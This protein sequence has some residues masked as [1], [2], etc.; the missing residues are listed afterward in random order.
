MIGNLGEEYIDELLEL[1]IGV[2]L[3][4]E[5]EVNGK[6]ILVR[7]DLNL[8]ITNGKVEDTTRLD[9]FATT[10][11]RELIEKD[12][13][14]AILTH[15]GRK[16]GKDF[17]TTEIHAKLLSEKVGDV[18]YIPSL[19]GEEAEEAMLSLR[20]GEKKAIILENTRF[21]DEETKK[22]P[23]EEH[24]KSKIVSVLSKHADFFVNDAFSSSHR[25][26]ASIVGFPFVLPSVAGRVM[27][28]ELRAIEYILKKKNDKTLYILGGAKVPESL[29]VIEFLLSKNKAMKIAVGGAVANAFVG[30]GLGEEVKKAFELKKRF[31]EK[32]YVPEDF[33]LEE[34]SEVPKDIGDKSVEKIKGFMD[35][36]EQIFING[37]LGVFEEGY[38]NS[39]KIFSYAGECKAFTVAGGGHTIILLK[40]LKLL[41]KIDHVS[42]GGRALLNAIMEKPLPGV[43]SLKKS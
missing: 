43:E 6:V 22:V 34:E 4:E 12:A 21:Y 17:T 40:K 2:P 13:K 27:E 23:M 28:W 33:V 19:Y 7:A 38:E 1:D 10:T 24:A 18:E 39:D 32:I 3:L 15:Q 30:I 26:H 37:P 42:T 20:K 35:N 14:V 8:P 16:G 9:L 31:G 25:N 5:L 36:A 29:E 11:L 41:E